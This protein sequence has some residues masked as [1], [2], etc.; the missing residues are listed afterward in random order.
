M[1]NFS[2][3]FS[4]GCDPLTCPSSST[5]SRFSL[6]VSGSPGQR[7]LHQVYN[8][9][10][11]SPGRYLLLALPLCSWPRPLHFRWPE[12]G[13][14]ETSWDLHCVQ[15]PDTVPSG[16]LSSRVLGGFSVVPKAC[17][18]WSRSSSAQSQRVS[19]CLREASV[20]NLLYPLFF[21]PSTHTQV[22]MESQGSSNS[23]PFQQENCNSLPST[24]KASRHLK[25]EWGRAVSSNNG[26]HNSCHSILMLGNSTEKIRA[27][28][29]VAQ[30]HRPKKTMLRI[31]AKDCLSPKTLMPSPI[32][33]LDFF[34]P[35][36]VFTSCWAYQLRYA[37]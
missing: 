29:W 34:C 35:M 1:S 17:S 20:T 37:E 24:Q 18:P 16:L 13:S 2:W 9:L 26:D 22:S 31:W 23:L 14:R 12:G 3:F 6:G 7:A 28:E 5:F 21:Q 25:E 11:W 4:P 15:S 10:L 30:G 27:V 19:R 33:G 8:L 32:K 36:A